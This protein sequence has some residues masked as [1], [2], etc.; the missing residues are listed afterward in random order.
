MIGCPWT[1]ITG[2]HEHRK[3][4]PHLHPFFHKALRDMG[5]TRGN[6]PMIQLR[7]SG[8]GAGGGSEKNVQEPG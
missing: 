1:F 8:H 2:G 3:Y 6:E 7:I 4:A 5:I